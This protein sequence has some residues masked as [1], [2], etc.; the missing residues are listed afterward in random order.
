MSRRF[1]DLC[2]DVVS[3]LGIAGG[4]I[5]SV[6]GT[7]NQEQLRVINWVA[8]ADLYVQNLWVDWSFLWYADPA[9]LVQANSDVLSPSLPSWAANIQT[10]ETGSLWLGAGTASAKPIRFTDW[11]TFRQL[12]QRKLKS[13]AATP[14]TWSKQPDGKLLLSQTMQGALTF[15]LDYHCIGKRMVS[16]NDT[17]PIPVNFDQII[18]EK[19]KMYYAEREN[20][21]EIMSGAV[22][23]YTDMLDKMQAIFLPDNTA[24]RRSKNNDDSAPRAYVE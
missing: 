5:N 21:Q 15:T 23:E 17:S 18:C 9:V 14:T 10:V 16:D 7:L 13:S 19:A 4:V 11:D 8:R 3:D 12:F 22:A 6:T 1:L 20:A 2:K 24:G